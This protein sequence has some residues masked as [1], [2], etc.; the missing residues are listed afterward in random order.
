[1]TLCRCWLLKIILL[2]Y[3]YAHVYS[4]LQY[5]IL[6]WGAADKK[7][8]MKLNIIHNRII[9]AL[10]PHKLL[11]NVNICTHSIFKNCELLKIEDIYKLEL[12][13]FMHCAYHNSLPTNLQNLFTSSESV[14]KYPTRASKTRSFYPP[15]ANKNIFNKWI[16]IEG[17]NL[18][19][20]VDNELKKFNLKIFYRKFKNQIIYEY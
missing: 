1:M 11:I 16:T 6:T 7:Q 4:K 12:A 10:S 9:Q 3:Y 17:I 14:H 18:W 2:Y 5:D 8:L 13:K 15:R 19:Q 20:K